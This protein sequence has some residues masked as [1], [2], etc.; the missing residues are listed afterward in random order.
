MTEEAGSLGLLELNRTLL[1]RQSLLRGSRLGGPE[2]LVSRMC[3]LN[4]QYASSA[5]LSAWVRTSDFSEEAFRR[6]ILNGGMVRASLMRGTLHIVAKE[7]YLEWRPLMQPVLRRVVNSFF[8]GLLN[9]LS[10]ERLAHE[11]KEILMNGPLTRAEMWRR[12]THRFSGEPPEAL[13]FAARLL[14][15][16]IQ[17][18]SPERWAYP[19][20]PRYAWI[21]IPKE[22]DTDKTLTSLFLSYLKA[23][24]PASL[25]D[26]Q[27]WSGLTYTAKLRDIASSLNLLTYRDQSGQTLFDTRDSKIVDA[28]TPAPVRLLPDY[29][30]ILF[31]H[32]SRDRVI[33]PSIRPHVI[34]GTPRMPGTILI[35]GFV[36]GVWRAID[37]GEGA[38]RLRIQL[39]KHNDPTPELREEAGRLAHYMFK[40]EKAEVK[41]ATVV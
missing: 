38:P 5:F 8:P 2:S 25:A 40:S 23:F 20:Q 16:L 17:V 1:E 10:L 39:F 32:R 4:A 12:L 14:L 27:A 31:A 30:N 24:G 9:R 33:D 6:S 28:D 41:Y 29:D 18:P 11:V 19:N 22:S 36:E 37:E 21:E 26:F 7:D 15:P 13:A 34:R 35:G 3:G